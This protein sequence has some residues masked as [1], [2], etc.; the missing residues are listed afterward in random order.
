M[1]RRKFLKLAG[2][3]GVGLGASMPLLGSSGAA[4]LG[5]APHS[6]GSAD[7]PLVAALDDGWTIATDPGNVGRGHS[8]FNRQ[9]SDAVPIRVPSILQEVFPDYHG[10]VWYWLNFNAD[11]QRYRDGRYLLRFHAVDYLAEV[12]LNGQYLGRHEGGDTPFVLDATSALR[13]GAVNLLAVRVLNPGKDSVDGISLLETA[14]RNKSVEY[15]S[16]TLYDYGGILEPVELLVVPAVY[17]SDIFLR[18]DWETGRVRVQLSLHNA[19]AEEATTDLQIAVRPANTDQ[20][21][22]ANTWTDRVPRGEVVLDHEFRIQNHRLWSLDDPRLYRLT[23]TLQARG[24]EGRH[25]VSASFGFRDFRVVNGYFRLN[26]KRIFVRS[27]HTGNNVP[28][29]QVVPPPCCPDMLRRDLL[30]AKTSGFNTIRF[31]SGAAHPYQLDLCDEIGLLVNEE[32]SASW[33]LKDSPQMKTRYTAAVR[34]MI[35]R[36]R[37][38]PSV[39]MWGML[40]ET[41]EGPVFR[42][43]ES[44]LPLVRALDDS[45]LVL[46]NSGRWDANLGIG[47]VSNPGSAQWD[48]VWGRE[49]PGAGRTTKGGPGSGD[50]HYYPNPPDTPAD[51][52]FIRT[53]GQGS[54]P[55]F[56]SEFGVGSMM[57]VIHEKRMY[58]EAGIREDAPDYRLMSSMADAFSADWIRFGMNA[59]YPFPETLLFMSQLRMARERILNFD[60]VRSNPAICGYN[61]TGMLDHG[62]VGEGV[63]RFWR[64]WKP[65]AF[66]AMR[67]GWAPVRW[68]LFIE[69][70]HTYAGRSFSVEA[71]LANE[72]RVRPGQ[73]PAHLRIWGPQGLAW[74]RETPIVIPASAPGQDGPLAVPVLKEQVALSAPAGGYRLAPFIP[75]GIAPPERSK[76]FYLSD[77]HSLPR[78]QLEVSTWK[79][80]E[81]VTSWLAAHGVTAR[82]LSGELPEKPGAILVGD[83][84]AK[85]ASLEEWKMLAARMAVGCTVVFLA[86]RAFQRGKQEAAWLPL[87]KKGRVYEFTDWLYHKECVAKSH[88]IFDGLQGNGILDWDYYGPMIPHY[89]FEGQETPDEVI[90][91]AFATGYWPGNYHGGILMGSYRFF[92][93]RFLVNTFPVLDQIDRHPAADRMLLNLIQVTARKDTAPVAALPEDF[94]SRLREIGFI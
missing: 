48:W 41:I 82:P 22:L 58:E 62:M 90:A 45:R 65:G 61:L 89:L 79:M 72:D 75:R 2:R 77:P 39:V 38:H 52:H 67:D 13:Y 55:V 36:D 19:L 63:W 15:V 80:P 84:S 29:G 35:L 66:D 16:G 47:S 20:P 49:A 87:A 69:P 56:L 83:V 25:D 40:N 78:P 85:P 28:F 68:C 86:P 64:D 6:G 27:T 92:E 91:A 31:I 30:Y 71:V 32:S 50:V 94:D 34:N 23:A 70:T 10:V 88:P 11:L 18:P 74:E 33:E 43:A 44:S 7:L 12:W 54:K 42:A 73:Y 81:S 21:C 14:H 93:G 59:V 60:L 4:T 24:A 8:W 76:K 3:M 37:N 9:A 17:V 5:M 53:L 1:R 26:G 57:D 46:L 51:R